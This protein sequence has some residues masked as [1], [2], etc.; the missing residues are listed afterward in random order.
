M[1]WRTAPDKKKKGK[2][3][4][5][6]NHVCLHFVSSAVLFL[7]FHDHRTLPLLHNLRPS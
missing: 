5:V 1:K 3:D 4:I 6:I 2:E 7:S